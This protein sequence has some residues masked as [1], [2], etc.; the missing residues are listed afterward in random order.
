MN[1]NIKMIKRPKKTNDDLAKELVISMASV[2][3]GTLNL[4][5]ERYKQNFNAYWANADIIN[6]FL[7]TEAK[8][9]FTSSAQ[10][11]EIIQTLD[12]EWQ[13]LTAPRTFTVNEDGTVT[14]GSAPVV[15]EV[16][17]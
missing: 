8:T 15:L 12:T 11:V 2:D 3:E 7:G 9:I 17:P 6:T 16:A 1:L 14:L 10:W 4:L 13:P 5:K